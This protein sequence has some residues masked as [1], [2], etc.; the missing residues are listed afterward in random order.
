MEMIPNAERETIYKERTKRVRV[1]IFNI[2]VG[3]S[4]V[5]DKVMWVTDSSN[6]RHRHL[7]PK[8]V[9]RF[10]SELELSLI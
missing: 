8:S 5:G 2:F 4:D 6:I 1:G 9:K 7:S 3:H 10:V